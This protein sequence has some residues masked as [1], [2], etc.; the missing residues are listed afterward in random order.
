MFQG[1]IGSNRSE[2]ACVIAAYNTLG[3]AAAAL[4]NHEFDYGPLDGASAPPGSLPQ[5]AL[6]TRIAE[7]EFPILSANL[8]DTTGQVPSWKNLFPGAI[9]DVGDVALGFIGVVTRETPSIVMPDY[10]AGLEVAPLAPAIEAEARALRARGA[11][12]VVVIAHAGAECQSFDDPHDLS[13]CDSSTSEL[14]TTIRQVEPSLV[15][16]WIGGHTHAGIA[17]YLNGKP[18][19]EAFSRGKA[20]GRIDLVLAGTPRRVREAKVFPPES[21]CPD[22]AEL[23][24]CETHDYA[25]QRVTA[26]SAVAAVIAPALDAAR[27]ERARLL[28]TDIGDELGADHDVESALGNLFVDL[29]RSYVPEADIA[30]TNGGSLRAKLPAGPLSYGSLYEAMPFDNRLVTLTLTGKELEAVV[31]AHLAT[32][33]HG[34][35]SISGATIEARCSGP[36]L[37]VSVVRANG[38]PIGDAERVRIATS[39]YLATGGDR[40]FASLGEP[41]ARIEKAFPLFLR[42]A[43]ANE[44]KKRPRIRTRDL[45]DPKRPRLTLPTNRPVRCDGR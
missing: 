23:A 18:V 13:S 3:L 26:S 1:T 2:G 34:L 39:D 12:A 43:L 44:V 30:I 5:G 17:H 36:T 9:I 31:A 38:R 14:C 4:G 24:P 7:A 33:A 25:G 21:L 28:G 45:L 8:R 15:D 6:I 35:I 42:D 37:E 40:L 19:V 32:D 10:F 27:I 20:F 29:M 41:R 11:H 16:A 22:S